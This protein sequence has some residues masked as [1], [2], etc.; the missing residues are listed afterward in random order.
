MLHFLYSKDTTV[1]PDERQRV[2]QAFL[3]IIH[4]YSGLRPS[5][6]TQSSKARRTEE[7]GECGEGAEDAIKLRYR[8]VELR[9]GEDERGRNRFAVRATFKYFKGGNRRPQRFAI[10]HIAERSCK[11]TDNW[12]V[13]HSH[14]PTKRTYSRALSP[15]LSR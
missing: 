9:V 2:Q 8:D 12:T 4:A 3:M 5:S 1:Y 13:R 14:G 6:T 15:T 10:S 7:S 11:S